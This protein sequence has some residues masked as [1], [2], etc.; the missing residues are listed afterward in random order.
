MSLKQEYYKNHG[1]G[2]T[3]QTSSPAP[4]NQSLK[5]EYYNNYGELCS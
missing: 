1:G 4:Q 3:T 5:Q 2:Q